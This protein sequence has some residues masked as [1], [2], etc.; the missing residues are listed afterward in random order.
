MTPIT[1]IPQRQRRRS[2]DDMRIIGAVIVVTALFAL[3]GPHAADAATHAPGAPPLVVASADIQAPSD[4]QVVALADNSMRIF[5][6]SVRERSMQGLWEHISLRFR[7]KFSVA[8]LDDVFKD[9]YD[10]KITGDPLA[11]RSPIFTAGP[12]INDDGNLVVDGYYA[13]TPWRVSFHL[14]FA[15]EGRAWKLIG[16]N[17]NAKPPTSPAGGSGGTRNSTAAEKL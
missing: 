6:A 5:M 3:G 17:V 11:G 7:E 2:E 15:M 9:F 4:D 1:F 12:V 14:A 8:Q 10:L 16:I 13:T